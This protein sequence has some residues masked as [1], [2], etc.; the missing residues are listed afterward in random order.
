[1]PPPKP[2]TLALLWTVLL[3]MLLFWMVTFSRPPPAIAMPPPKP[4][5]VLP[6]M[7][8]PPLAFSWIFNEAPPLLFVRRTLMPPPWEPAPPASPVVLLETVTWVRVTRGASPNR[9]MPPPVLAW[10]EL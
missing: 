6:V 10:V 8:E 2:A 9:L 5:P 1:M 4:N 7:L 3:V